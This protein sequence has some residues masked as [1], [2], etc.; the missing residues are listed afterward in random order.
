MKMSWVPS[1]KWQLGGFSISQKG[2]NPK[3]WEQQQQK[4]DLL[5]WFKSWI[6]HYAIIQK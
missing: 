2:T 6:L 1:F 4:S 5:T 3:V